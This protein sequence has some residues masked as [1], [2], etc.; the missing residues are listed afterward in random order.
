[1]IRN[2]IG[3]GMIVAALLVTLAPAYTQ[4]LTG[5]TRGCYADNGRY[6]LRG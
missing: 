4:S 5:R 6:H 3:I 1:M 2:V